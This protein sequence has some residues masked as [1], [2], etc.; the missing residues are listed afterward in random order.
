MPTEDKELI[1]VEVPEEDEDKVIF[2]DP[3]LLE[4]ILNETYEEKSLN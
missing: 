2:I 3:E 4:E 1:I